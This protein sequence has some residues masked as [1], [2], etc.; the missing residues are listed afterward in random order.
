MSRARVKIINEEVN[1]S[2]FEDL[3]VGT[4]FEYEGKLHLKVDS[5]YEAV[6]LTNNQYLGH[7]IKFDC[8]DS[9]VVY[10]KAVITIKTRAE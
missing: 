7:V 4:V 6:L 3:D 10:D 9:V 1:I 8:D 5:G 2:N